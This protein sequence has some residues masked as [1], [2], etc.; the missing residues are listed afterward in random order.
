MAEPD[1]S[2]FR[3]RVH[4]CVATPCFGHT[5]FVN[6]LGSIIQLVQ[7]CR[8]RFELSF[9]LRSGDAL[10]T[11]CRNAIAAEFLATPHFTHLL[12]IDADIGFA[13]EAVFR[14]LDSGHDVVA[15]VYP[16]KDPRGP[17]AT[18]RAP[19]AFNPLPTATTAPANGFA[20]VLDVPAGF[21]LIR[22][23]AFERL[24]AADPSLR[25][26]PD[27][28]LGRDNLENHYCFFDTL[29]DRGRYLSEGHAFCRRWQRAGGR[30][31]IDVQS[32]L[33]HHGSVLFEGDLLHALRTRGQAPDEARA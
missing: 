12:W 3:D 31:F 11:R 30:V 33:T 18:G 10:I 1:E 21:M 26:T 6:Y 28:M 17:G 4:L 9:I 32:R 14:L 5:V 19:Y 29:M 23:R 7:A 27:P 24:I 2:R 8:D 13:P 15:G 20:E 25:Y 16:L 22:R